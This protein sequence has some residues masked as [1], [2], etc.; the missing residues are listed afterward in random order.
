L[1]LSKTTWFSAITAVAVLGSMA[2]PMVASANGPGD[3]ATATERAAKPDRKPEKIRGNPLAT[4]LGITP[5][6]LAAATKAAHAAVPKPAPELK[7]DEAA[8]KAYAAAIEAALAQ[9]LGITVDALNAAQAAV[10][11]DSGAKNEERRAAAAEK[12]KAQFAQVLTRLVGAGVITQVQADEIMVQYNLGGD[13][14]KTVLQRL[15]TLLQDEKAEQGFTQMLTRLVGA[16]ILTQ[17]QA[18]EALAQ[19]NLGGDAKESVI[20][21][22]RALL[23]EK[24]DDGDKKRDE[25]KNEKREKAEPKKPALERANKARAGKPA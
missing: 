11:T 14:Q 18:D 1:N 5:E 10:K 2:L 4:A 8:R 7:K 23:Q 21:R 12:A 20:K 19:F 6:V 24:K 16:G 13:A 3:A 15:R 17:A 9:E 25:K 22:I